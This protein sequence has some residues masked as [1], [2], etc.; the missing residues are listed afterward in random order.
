MSDKQE[1]KKDEQ[2][3]TKSASSLVFISHDARDAEIA[4]AFSTLLKRV[5]AGVLKSFRSSDK[6]GNQGIEYGV[7][8]YPEIIKNIQGATDVVCLLTP[9]SVDRPWILFEAGMAKGKLNTPILGVALGLTLKKASSGPFAQFQNCSGDEDSLCKLVFQLVDRIPNSEPDEETIKFHVQKFMSS[10]E[11]IFT[12]RK[13][14]PED[15]SIAEYNENDTPKLFEEIKVMFQDLPS[16]IENRI[17]PESRDRKR[18]RRFHPSM[19]E[20]LIHM[21]PNPTVGM[22]IALGLVKDK[23]PWLYEIGTDT[24][25]TLKSDIS[26]KEKERAVM[27]FAEMVETTTHH[28]MIEEF[29]MVN[30]KED[31]MLFRE[32]PRMLRNNL[33]RLLMEI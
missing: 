9:N 6:K 30:S 13:K 31:Y 22:Y 18:T 24:I 27:E 29:Y 32:L 8:W 2:S 11:D 17:D 33:Q 26:I 12:K 7:E 21:T 14:D 25:K 20:K 23:M 5:S 4:E 3:S 10:I 28:P 19:I 1:E 15:D 16:R